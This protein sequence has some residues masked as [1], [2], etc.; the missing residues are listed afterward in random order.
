M[1]QDMN[2]SVDNTSQSIGESPRLS[3]DLANTP[4]HAVQAQCSIIGAHQQAFLATGLVPRPNEARLGQSTETALPGDLTQSSNA[5]RQQQ[6]TRTSPMSSLDSFATAFSSFSNVYN[7]PFSE[8]VD[9]LDAQGLRQLRSQAFDQLWKFIPRSHHPISRAGD[10]DDP[11]DGIIY[12]FE[13]VAKARSTLEYLYQAWLERDPASATFLQKLPSMARLCL[14]LA[15]IQ[16]EA[17]LEVLHDQNLVDG[18]LPFNR[19]LADKLFEVHGQ[20][21]AVAFCSE[22]YRAVPRVWERGQHIVL[23]T[24]EPLPLIC[25]QTNDLKVRD[26]FSGSYY[27]HIQVIVN[28]EINRNDKA[29][30]HFIQELNRFKDFETR[31]VVQLVK[32]YQRGNIY[33]QLL[34]PPTSST[35]ERLLDRYRKNRFYAGE[36]CKDRV[37]L[38]PLLLQAFGCLS[39]DLQYCHNRMMVY[40]H[41]NPALIL[42]EKASKENGGARFLWAVP[43]RD[44]RFERETV[45]HLGVISYNKPPHSAPGLYKPSRKSNVFSLGRVFREMLDALLNRVPPVGD[46]A[47]FNVPMQQQLKAWEGGFGQS[48]EL[49]L[50]VSMTVNMMS[51]KASDRP[52]M[53]EVVHGFAA[54]GSSYFCNKCWSEMS[55]KTIL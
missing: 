14:V 8:F 27:S 51:E 45:E 47:D 38:R 9:S 24:M 31:H 34:Q 4:D 43:D 53:D 40:E 10:N 48:P 35:L 13:M 6:L 42:F 20:D 49:S 11:G 44:N 3:E 41:I 33:G 52:F 39:R 22:Q 5:T 28:E 25:D 26:S 23:E 21:I 17:L 54:A 29:E 16:R 30:E 15:S 18:D 55:C 7:Q 36:G 46:S 12:D 2:T 1:Q 50:L 37:W 32:S 19:D